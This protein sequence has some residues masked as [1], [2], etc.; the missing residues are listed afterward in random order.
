MADFAALFGTGKSA[1]F[2]AE[3][4]G[5]KKILWN[6]RTVDLDKVTGAPAAELMQCVGEYFLS[7]AGFSGKKNGSSGIGEDGNG[8]LDLLDS[9]RST[10]DIIQWIGLF[11]QLFNRLL[12]QLILLLHFFNF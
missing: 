6:S 1:A 10:D 11:T 7:N 12:I 5:F 3:K 4:L 2:V 8:G 9:L